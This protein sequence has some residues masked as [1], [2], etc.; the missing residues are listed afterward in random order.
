MQKKYQ[1]YY[2]KNRVRLC[3]KQVNVYMPNSIKKIGNIIPEKILELYNLHPFE[4]YD[5]YLKV[6]LKIFGIRNGDIAFDECYDAAMIGYMYSI[7]RCAYM[8]YEHIEN[9]IKFMIRCCIKF[10]VVLANK[11]R[12][13]ISNQDMKIVYLDSEKNPRKY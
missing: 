1:E 2:R 9:Y 4:K 13:D 10:G 5:S 8:N 12:Y 11:E 6:K 3:E 7:H